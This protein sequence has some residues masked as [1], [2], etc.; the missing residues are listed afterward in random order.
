MKKEVI[1]DFYDLSSLCNDDLALVGS[2]L[3]LV[4]NP[5]NKKIINDLEALKIEKYEDDL[6]FLLDNLK[7]KTIKNICEIIREK[8]ASTNDR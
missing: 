6:I 4:Q 8:R 2:L 5:S 7:T 3:L 1:Q